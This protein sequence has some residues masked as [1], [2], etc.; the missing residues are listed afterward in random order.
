MKN[1]RG[2]KIMLYENYKKSKIEYEVQNK[3]YKSRKQKY[4]Q[5]KRL[6]NNLV[7]ID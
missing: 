4:W 6:Q 7:L 1:M 5:Y 3:F 2:N